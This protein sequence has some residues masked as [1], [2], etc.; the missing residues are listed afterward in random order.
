MKK[1]V[2]NKNYQRGW[3]LLAVI[4]MLLCYLYYS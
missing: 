4:G 2:Q 1:N 3:R